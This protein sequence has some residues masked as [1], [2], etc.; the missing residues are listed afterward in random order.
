MV[1]DATTLAD[2]WQKIKL[3]FAKREMKTEEIAP[4][5][6][7]DQA[8]KVASCGERFCLLDARSKEEY[9]KGTLTN[10]MHWG[11][12]RTRHRMISMVRWSLFSPI[13][14]IVVF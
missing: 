4:G 2:V 6:S 11:G 7:F 13:A 5:L 9:E 1:S 12:I 10:A 8:G 14:G 3:F